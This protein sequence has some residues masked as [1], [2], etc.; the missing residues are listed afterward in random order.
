MLATRDAAVA[1]TASADARAAQASA[2]TDAAQEE[3]RAVRA[4]LAHVRG[5][6][7][8][9][10]NIIEEMRRSASWRATAPLRRV[11]SLLKER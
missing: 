10:W 8:G 11:K 1:Q 6:L 5:D 7:H 4:E 9:S 2:E 3:L